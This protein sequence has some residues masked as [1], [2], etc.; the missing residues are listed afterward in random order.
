M[1]SSHST[2]V[3]ATPTRNIGLSDAAEQ[4]W[5]Q[6]TRGRHLL[7]AVP[8]LLEEDV[9]NNVCNQMQAALPLQRAMGFASARRSMR[10]V[11][12]SHLSP[13]DTLSRRNGERDA[14]TSSGIRT[15]VA[16]PTRQLCDERF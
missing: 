7:P 12:N 11:S 13:E 8:G 2:P 4:R 15:S 9:Q 3:R 16:Y 10:P 6:M 5:R 14:Q 1:A